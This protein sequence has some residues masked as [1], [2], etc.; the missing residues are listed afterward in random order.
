MQPR[1]GRRHQS[2]MLVAEETEAAAGGAER[3][4]CVVVNRRT[5]VGRR[6]S[7]EDEPRRRRWRLHCHYV[8]SAALLI[9][10][11]QGLPGRH[12][13]AE[14]VVLPPQRP[15][16]VGAAETDWYPMVYEV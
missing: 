10:V 4:D 11:L 9:A 8:S 7:C 12:E 1:S 2:C 15:L 3:I 13:A 5:A 16:T 14:W 6:M